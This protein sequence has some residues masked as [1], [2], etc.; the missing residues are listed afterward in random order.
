MDFY[1]GVTCTFSAASSTLPVP[2][3][4][5]TFSAGAAIVLNVCEHLTNLPEEVE[6]IWMYVSIFL[7]LGNGWTSNVLT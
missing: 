3:S 6:L 5:L 7:L 1:R 2:H 4:L